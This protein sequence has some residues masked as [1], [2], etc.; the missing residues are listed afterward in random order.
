[1]GTVVWTVFA[2]GIMIAIFATC[3]IVVAAGTRL[4]ENTLMKRRRKSLS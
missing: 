3:V 4:L 2:V 1:M